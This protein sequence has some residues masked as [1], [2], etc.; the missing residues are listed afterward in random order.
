MISLL[1]YVFF[2]LPF[3]IILLHLG[4]CLM[5]PRQSKYSGKIEIHKM[6]IEKQPSFCVL[7]FFSNTLSRIWVNYTKVCIEKLLKY[8]V[9]NIGLLYKTN[10]EYQHFWKSKYGL[11]RK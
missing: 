4:C 5:L 9:P 8:K 7:L 6:C 3:T 11:Q 2:I 10:S 1:I